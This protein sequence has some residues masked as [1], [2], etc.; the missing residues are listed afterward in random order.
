MTS[1]IS[2]E[3]GNT[4]SRFAFQI[5]RDDPHFQFWYKGQVVV[6][7]KRVEY[8]KYLILVGK[9]DKTLHVLV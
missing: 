8:G 6:G 9:K 1:T 2:T 5:T 4:L 3:M 7:M